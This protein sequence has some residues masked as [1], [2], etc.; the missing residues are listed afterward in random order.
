M[1][2][3]FEE[4]KQKDIMRTLLARKM[5]EDYAINSNLVDCVN[6]DFECSNIEDGLLTYSVIGFEVTAMVELD[7][8]LSSGLYNDAIKS[9]L[10]E[11]DF[12]EKDENNISESEIIFYSVSIFTNKKAP[13]IQASISLFG[14]VVL[15]EETADLSSVEAF[16]LQC[17][18]FI[19]AL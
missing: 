17:A 5:S 14:K 1:S 12:E 19:A 6:S 4:S 18:R 7:T 15:L 11:S 3:H 16:E 10:S 13:V 2:M 8:A 9:Q